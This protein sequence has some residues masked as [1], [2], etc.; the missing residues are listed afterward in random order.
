MSLARGR[1]SWLS[2]ANNLN[3]SFPALSNG[4]KLFRGHLTH[5]DLQPQ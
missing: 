3:P 2:M 4:G 1:N 5:F